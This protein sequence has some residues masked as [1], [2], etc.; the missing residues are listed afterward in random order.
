MKSALNVL[1]V[2]SCGFMLC[3]GLSHA[4]EAYYNGAQAVDE[5]KADHSSVRQ[6]R[7]EIG[8]TQMYEMESGQSQGGKKRK[9]EV[10][11]VEGTKC[12]V[13]GQEGKEGRLRIDETTPKARNTSFRIQDDSNF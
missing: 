2:L 5:L 12:F 8:K 7:Q 11:R 13:Q 4:A 10:L 3:L 6:G 9:G 1:G